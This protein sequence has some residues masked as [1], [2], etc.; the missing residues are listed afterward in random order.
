MFK[1]FSRTRY[2]KDKILKDLERKFSPDIRVEITP[3]DIINFIVYSMQVIEKYNISGFEKKE[4]VV[5]IIIDIFEKYESKIKNS[6]YIKNF[7]TNILPS[8]INILISI[9]RQ[10]IFIKLENSLAAGCSFV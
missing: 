9:D 3:K 6:A 8:L 1:I 5:S 2:S 10:E 7:L 4:L